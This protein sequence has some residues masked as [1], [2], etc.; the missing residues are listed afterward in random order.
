MSNIDSFQIHL[1]SQT[2]DKI[3]SNNNCD[4]EL[5]TSH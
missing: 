2:A 1:T 5:F 3:Y 4:A